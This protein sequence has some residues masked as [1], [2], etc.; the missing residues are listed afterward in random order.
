MDLAGLFP[1]LDLSRVLIRL[2]LA[3]LSCFQS[4]KSLIALSLME[5]MVA[6][7]VLWNTLTTSLNTTPLRLRMSTLIKLLTLSALKKKD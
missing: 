6:L 2:Q 1:L 4:S 3:K 7:E 5:T